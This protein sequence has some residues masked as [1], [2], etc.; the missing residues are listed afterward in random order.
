MD[1]ARCHA[2]FDK[3]HTRQKERLAYR[4][5]H[6]KPHYD[7]FPLILYQRLRFMPNGLIT[8]VIKQMRYTSGRHFIYDITC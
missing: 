2:A 1:I 7:D 8:K 5:Q 3:A 4:V 6:V